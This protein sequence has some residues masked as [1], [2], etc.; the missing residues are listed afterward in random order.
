M[1]ESYDEGLLEGDPGDEPDE[2]EPEVHSPLDSVPATETDPRM[3]TKPTIGSVQPTENE[4]LVGWKQ[5]RNILDVYARYSFG[6]GQHFLRVERIEPKVWGGIACAGPLGE[7]RRP[8]TEKEFCDY[9]GGRVYMLQVYGPDPRGRRDNSTGLPIVK[10]KTEP[11]RFIVPHHPPNLAVRPGSIPLTNGEPQMHPSQIPGFQ[12]HLPSTPADAAI[13]KTQTDF[14]QNLLTSKDAEVE[15]LR[16]DSGTP[17]KDLL[18]IVHD[19][20]KDALTQANAAAALREKSLMEQMDREREEKKEA[21]LRAE[22]ERKELTAKFEALT[23]QLQALQSQPRESPLKEAAA[24]MEKVN[25]AK[26]AEDEVIRLRASHQEELNRV[27]EQHRDAMFQAN[28]RHTDELK[29]LR[30]RIDEDEKHARIRLEDAEKR[31]RERETELRTQAEQIR[32]DER[33]QTATRL[34]DQEDR[35]KDRLSD[36]QKAFERE[37]RM[38][39]EQHGTRTEVTA[40]KWDTQIQTQKETIARLNE[41]VEELKEELEKSKDPVAVMEKAEK[42]ATAL[43]YSK[44]SPDANQTTGERFVGMLGMGFGKALETVPDWLPKALAS[45]GEGRARAAAEAPRQ[46]PQGAPG[47]GQGQ[48]RQAPRQQSRRTVS[49]ATQGSVPIAGQVPITPPDSP[50]VQQHTPPP[51]PGQAAPVQ[52]E[53]LPAQTPTAPEQAQQPM[54]QAAPMQPAPEQQAPE[55][56]SNGQVQAAL[57]IFGPQAIQ[58]FRAHLESAIT[59][60]FPP[61]AFADQFTAA[62]PEPSGVLVSQHKPEELFAFVKTMP[63]GTES[64]ILRRDGKRWVEKMWQRVQA[65]HQQRAQ[66]AQQGAAS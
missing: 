56:Q 6:D 61:D 28:E 49:W 30:D 43:G 47:Q 40:S 48:Q 13:F 7:I 36:Q 17:G 57:G 59:A 42:T 1:A 38:Q 14:M 52:A 21:A 26:T 9:Y 39:T 53:P 4:D 32:R 29:R 45:L 35:Y 25:P 66:A 63:N 20:S 2:P 62:W 51:A 24:F 11:F 46:L 65:L 18:S 33:E 54:P 60:G 55:Q 50:P 37:L 3:R 10:A 64:V 22:A 16:K 19:T 44:E 23:A 8:I 12:A 41:E 5:P 27:R 58:E 15:R 31:H 34:K